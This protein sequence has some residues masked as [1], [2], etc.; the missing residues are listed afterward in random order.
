MNSEDTHI[1]LIEGKN[2][3]IISF[4][5]EEEAKRQADEINELVRR[6]YL[7]TTT[8]AQMVEVE[9]QENTDDLADLTMGGSAAGDYLQHTMKYR[10]SEGIWYAPE[11][12]HDKKPMSLGKALRHA[13]I[14]PQKLT[15]I[16]REKKK[17]L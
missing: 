17:T 4:Y 5:R 10:R 7:P 6:G 13:G 8:R 11:D 15:K 2:I 16:I 3:T 9:S 12:T 14:T 1:A